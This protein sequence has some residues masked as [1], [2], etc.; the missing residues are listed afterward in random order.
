VE[1]LVSTGSKPVLGLGAEDFALY[2]NGVRQQIDVVTYERTPLDV[3]VSIEAVE[4]R[5]PSRWLREGPSEYSG[6]IARLLK[7]LRSEDRLRAL[8]FAGGLV[9]VFGWTDAPKMPQLTLGPGLPGIGLRDSIAQT[10]MLDSDPARRQVLV[11]FAH[12]ADTTS[13]ISAGQLTEV[14][15]RSRSQLYLVLTEPRRV[16]GS[17][18]SAV[19]TTGGRILE[20]GAQRKVDWELQ[21]VFEYIRA[22]YLLVYV[23]QGAPQRGWHEVRIEV[24]GQQRRLSI[25]ARKGYHVQ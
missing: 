17:I 8:A 20:A 18:T 21:R 13:V 15:S 12:G 6:T 19:E 16:A 25:A 11:V 5:L 1:V 14:A 24:P 7:T 10:L 23:P 22:T 3:S 2:D 4:S 9:E